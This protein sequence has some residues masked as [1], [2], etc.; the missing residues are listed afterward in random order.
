LIDL[1][2]WPRLYDDPCVGELPKPVPITPPFNKMNTT[3][4]KILSILFESAFF[5]LQLGTSY[6]I[7][8]FVVVDIYTATKVCAEC[9]C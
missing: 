1:E 4:E 6:I 5:A 9:K 3:L 7:E 8:S 2:K